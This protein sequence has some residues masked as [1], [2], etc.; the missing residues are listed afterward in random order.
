MS[1]RRN[2]VARG[3]SQLQEFDKKRKFIPIDEWV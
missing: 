1:K 3:T 2:L